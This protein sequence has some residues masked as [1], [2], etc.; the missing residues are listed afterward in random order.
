M[1]YDQGMPTTTLNVEKDAY[2]RIREIDGELIHMGNYHG[3]EIP[4]YDLLDENGEPILPFCQDEHYVEMEYHGE[5][6]P[7]QTP[8]R[9]D[10]KTWIKLS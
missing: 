9:R 2:L 3:V 5:N 8:D 6:Y 1:N 7:I 10:G 4:A